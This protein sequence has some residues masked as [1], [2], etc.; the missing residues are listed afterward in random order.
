[1]SGHHHSGA[2]IWYA[3]CGQEFGYQSGFS[4]IASHTLCCCAF[5]G[6][7]SD[8]FSPRTRENQE[9]AVD[10]KH[11]SLPKKLRVASY[12]IFPT[13][14]RSREGPDMLP[15]CPATLAIGCH[16]IRIYKSEG[17]YSS[18]PPYFR[19]GGL[20]IRIIHYFNRFVEHLLWSGLLVGSFPAVL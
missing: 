6:C 1:M 15:A 2:D 17:C 10:S 11:H 20:L 7:I 18:K 16:Q 19:K 13:Y 4:C 5:F 9:N 12:Q 14:F 8:L 3:P